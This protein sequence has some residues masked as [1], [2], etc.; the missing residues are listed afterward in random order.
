M[1]QIELQFKAPQLPVPQ[2]P[3]NPT[4]AQVNH[5]LGVVQYNLSQRNKR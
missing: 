1:S 3:R 4:P 2:L 5:Y